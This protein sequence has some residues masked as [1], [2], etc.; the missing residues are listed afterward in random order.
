MLNSD[1]H[2]VNI[3]HW[4]ISIHQILQQQLRLVK[5]KNSVLAPQVVQN[6]TV[7]VL[8]IF[9]QFVFKCVVYGDIVSLT[10]G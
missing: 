1:L 9:T 7:S 2:F 10:F 6:L 4:N 3:Y 5:V 8:K